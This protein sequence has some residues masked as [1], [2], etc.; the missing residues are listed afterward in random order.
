MEQSN[1]KRKLNAEDTVP[2]SV[3]LRKIPECLQN[4]IK[5]YV[6]DDDRY[7][8]E[9][10]HKIVYESRGKPHLEIVP[11]R[12]HILVMKNMH[13][14]AEAMFFS[15]KTS[16]SLYLKSKVLNIPWYCIKCGVG[17]PIPDLED[18]LYFE[19]SQ[20]RHFCFCQVPIVVNYLYVHYKPMNIE[21][22]DATEESVLH[23]INKFTQ[24]TQH[25]TIPIP[26]QPKF[27]HR[28]RIRR[29]LLL[30]RRG[31]RIIKV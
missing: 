13:P 28:Y 14:T 27:E 23:T 4:K 26:Y 20:E 8:W 21:I 6:I 24:S 16:G 2:I 12:K 29:D 1:K 15:Y 30:R 19:K 9:R 17:M 7:F 18:P 25:H 5:E 31:R 3:N 11:G 10:L 22:E